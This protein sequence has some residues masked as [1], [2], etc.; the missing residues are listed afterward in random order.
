MTGK[1]PASKGA[2]GNN[3]LPVSG[4]AKSMRTERTIDQATNGP[5]NWAFQ[6]RL[7]TLTR[8]WL[9]SHILISLL[10]FFCLFQWVNKTLIEL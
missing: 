5:N 7:G 2:K 4:K 1:Q 3:G 6:A 8:P 9:G 10:A